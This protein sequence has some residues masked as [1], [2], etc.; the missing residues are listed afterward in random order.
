MLNVLTQRSCRETCLDVKGN[1]NACK[2]ISS[3]AGMEDI[4]HCRIWW[5][6]SI[7]WVCS[8]C[9]FLNM[10]SLTSLAVNACLQPCLYGGTYS[11]VHETLKRMGVQISQLR[12]DDPTS[13]FSLIQPNTKVSCVTWWSVAIASH[14]CTSNSRQAH[15]L[16]QVRYVW[17]CLLTVLSIC[18]PSLL[19]IMH[20]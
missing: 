18:I 11:F 15:S 1:H 8:A 12:M 9:L 14:T 20:A 10:A 17:L 7:V 4:Y 2:V 5:H 6:L 13:W 3:H 19:C 16:A